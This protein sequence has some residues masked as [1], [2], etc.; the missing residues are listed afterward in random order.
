MPSEQP[1]TIMSTDQ[2]P[3]EQK[4]INVCKQYMSIAY[5][6]KE[7]KGASSVQHLCHPDAWFWSPSTFPGK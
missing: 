1:P 5:N 7:N 4:N 3:D 6:P 2:T